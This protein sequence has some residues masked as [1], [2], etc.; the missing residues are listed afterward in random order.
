MRLR[1]S[2]FAG[3]SEGILDGALVVYQWV[4]S[5]VLHGLSGPGA[6][7]RFQPTCSEYA[8]IALREHGVF[9]GGGMA[10]RRLLRCH[11][12]SRGGFDRVPERLQTTS[13][14]VQD[15]SR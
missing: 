7:C 4:I 6:G 15:A 13:G 3:V 14:N 8:R 11:P 1:E 5:P 9:R 12:F 2:R 10:F